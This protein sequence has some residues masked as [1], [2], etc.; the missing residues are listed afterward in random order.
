MI[1]HLKEGAELISPGA[2]GSSQQHH[3]KKS[4]LIC[5]TGYKKL[6]TGNSLIYQNKLLS[7]QLLSDILD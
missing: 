7:E 2:T 1:N 3:N 4:C 6:E 5:G